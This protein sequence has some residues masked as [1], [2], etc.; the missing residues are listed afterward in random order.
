MDDLD[1]ILS[2][3]DDLQPSS[4]FADGVKAAI[5]LDSEGLPLPFPWGR[6]ALGLVACLVVAA[7]GSALLSP[8]V[9]AMRTA[10]Q[11]LAASSSVLLWAA[12]AVVGSGTVALLPAWRRRFAI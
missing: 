11:P 7:A 2:R 5:A 9:Q 4:G 6:W 1:R 3:D 12:I 8:A 10:L